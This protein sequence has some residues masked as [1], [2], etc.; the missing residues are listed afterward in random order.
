MCVYNYRLLEMKNDF[1]SEYISDGFNYRC[2][3]IKH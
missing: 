2:F 1:F 3:D